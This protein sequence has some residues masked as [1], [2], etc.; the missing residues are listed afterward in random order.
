MGRKK[1]RQNGYYSELKQ[2]GYEHCPCVARD[3]AN[4]REAHTSLYVSLKNTK[5]YHALTAKQRCLYEECMAQFSTDPY[6]D[7]YLE[8]DNI[9]QRDRR[10]SF[11]MNLALIQGTGIYKKGG[12]NT[13]YND[14]KQLE[15]WGF[16]DCIYH[17]K[18]K[19]SKSIYRLSE[20]WKKFELPNKEPSLPPK[21][22]K[23][24]EK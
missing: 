20:R 18:G 21:L 3:P 5:A 6:K 19:G 16:I 11:Y 8:Q 7:K 23:A 13:F 2:Q 1:S 15:A 24:E 9:T 14:L 4:L 22:G 17:G 12:K 10:E